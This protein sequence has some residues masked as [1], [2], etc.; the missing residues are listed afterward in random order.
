[1]LFCLKV[2]DDIDGSWKG[3]WTPMWILDIVQLLVV[4]SRLLIEILLFCP[5]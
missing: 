4:V 3:I 5:N 2:D 1:M